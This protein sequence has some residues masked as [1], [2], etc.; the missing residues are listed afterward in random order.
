MC[1]LIYAKHSGKVMAVWGESTSTGEHVIQRDYDTRGN[2]TFRFEPVGDGY[3][4]IVVE[5]SCKVM[6]V[7]DESTESG[8]LVIQWDRHNGDN[9]KWGYNLHRVQRRSLKRC[10]DYFSHGF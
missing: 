7:E 1:P 5:H 9:Q 3:Y 6:D 2:Q 4:R 8:A 10:S